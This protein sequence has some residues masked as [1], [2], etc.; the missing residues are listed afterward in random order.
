MNCIQKHVAQSFEKM[1]SDAKQ[2]GVS[3]FIVSGFRSYS[4]QKTLYNAYVM[5]DGK[6]SADTYSARP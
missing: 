6:K 5:R 3:L 1:K 2:E 4:R